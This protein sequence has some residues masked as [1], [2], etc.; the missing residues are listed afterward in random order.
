[1]TARQHKQLQIM[2]TIAER[3]ILDVLATVP[4]SASGTDIVAA[5]MVTGVRIQGAGSNVQAVGTTL[6]VAQQ[7][8]TS[9]TVGS[10]DRTKARTRSDGR[11]KTYQ[12]DVEAVEFYRANNPD[13][14]RLLFDTPINLLSTG[15]KVR[16][17]NS[18]GNALR[19]RFAHTWPNGG[20]VC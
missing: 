20:C 5:G 9:S 2:P 13:F 8:S 19:C 11:T 3:D 18:D 15:T 4:D 7:V 17:R 16:L 1:M 12:Q 10:A 14:A 6:V